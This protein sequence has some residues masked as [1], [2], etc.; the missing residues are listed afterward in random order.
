LLLLALDR[1]HERQAI[2]LLVH[3]AGMDRKLGEL[4]GVDRWGD[5]WAAERGVRI[6]R[7]PEDRATWGTGAAAIC[8]KQM[9]EAGAHG[10]VAF[11][12]APA[13]LLPAGLSIR[14]PGVATI[15]LAEKMRK[16]KR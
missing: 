9:T 4:L 16:L 1:V 14:D 2:T 13:S 10:C 8:A 3:G 6:E 7:H 5:E 11:P 15:R 12:G